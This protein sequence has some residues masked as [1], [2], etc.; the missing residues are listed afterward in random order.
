MN[1]CSVLIVIFDIFLNICYNV[2]IPVHSTKGVVMGT[3]TKSRGKFRF[4]T[5]DRGTW[6]EA[7]V[8]SINRLKGAASDGLDDYQITFAYEGRQYVE[9]ISHAMYQMLREKLK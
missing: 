2:T 3:E 1:T 9:R 4:P 7:D 6:I 8:I 5:I